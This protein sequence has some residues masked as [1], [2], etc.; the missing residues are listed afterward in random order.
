MLVAAGVKER[1]EAEDS[2]LLD[3]AGFELRQLL[4]DTPLV[5][6]YSGHN[7]EN[8]YSLYAVDP[9]YHNIT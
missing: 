8:A 5:F 6:I 4:L 9:F 3:T 7:D 1:T 2:V